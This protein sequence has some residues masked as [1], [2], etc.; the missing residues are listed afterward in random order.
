MS[1]YSETIHGTRELLYVQSKY[2][3]HIFS[4][5]IRKCACFC[6]FCIDVNGCGIYHCEND[7]YVKQWKCVPLNP[8]GPHPI[9]TRHEMQC[10]NCN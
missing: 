9:P 7:V 1:W 10:L 3:G 6:D 8:K 5:E 2:M 4:I